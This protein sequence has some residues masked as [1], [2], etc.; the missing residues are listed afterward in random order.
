MEKGTVSIYRA[1]RESCRSFTSRE[2]SG[3][4]HLK[5]SFHFDEDFPGF[6]GHFPGKPVL[7]AV[8][9]LA[10]IRC[11]TELSLELKLT[12]SGYDRVKFRGVVLPGGPTEVCIELR[13]EGD[14]WCAGFTIENS[15]GE[16]VSSG[17]CNFGISVKG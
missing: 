4:I 10:A 13:P 14:G 2:E 5:A 15:N 3:T 17:T 6:Q 8:V 7:P 11:V 1:L 16:S 12:P 9:Q